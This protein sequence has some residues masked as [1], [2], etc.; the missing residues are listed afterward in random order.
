MLN[1]PASAGKTTTLMAE[2]SSRLGEAVLRSRTR[3]AERTAR[4]EGEIANKVKSEF[5]SNMSHELRTPLNTVIGFSKLLAEH[6][7]R[8]LKQQDVAEYARLIQDAAGHL[9]SLINDILDISKLQSGRYYIDEQDVE[10]E[11]ILETCI[12]MHSKAATSAGITMTAKLADGLPVMRGDPSKLLQAISNFLSNAVKFTRDGGGIALEA[13]PRDMD[14]T[15]ILIR[16]TG[17]GM[18]EEE[19]KIAMTPFGQVDGGR[20]RWREG[21]GLGLPIAK[22]LIGLHGGSVDIT[23]AKGIGTE[24]RIFLPSKRHVS[25]MQ[26]RRDLSLPQS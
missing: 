21:A 6:E 13:R 5:I 4:I 10:L 11:D 14:G 12:K 2:Y 3:A 9:L 16:D 23:S 22:A 7:K 25:R 15:D 18:E 19:L 26:Q 8:N 20:S 1:G 17:V 24:V